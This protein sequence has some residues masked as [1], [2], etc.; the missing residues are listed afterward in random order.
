MPV[1]LRLVGVSCDYPYMLLSLSS[2]VNSHS[3][4]EHNTFDVQ[5][6]TSSSLVDCHVHPLTIMI[7]C[8]LEVGVSTNFG[9]TC[10]FDVIDVVYQIHSY[11]NDI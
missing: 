2:V 11:I 6:Q 10:I 7:F 9:S 1:G 5:L 3:P 4:E 8:V